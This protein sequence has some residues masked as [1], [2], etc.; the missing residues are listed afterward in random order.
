MGVNL[1]SPVL[2]NIF[3]DQNDF[4]SVFLF[5]VAVGV[6]RKRLSDAYFIPIFFKYFQVQMQIFRIYEFK[7][8]I[9]WRNVF[10]YIHKNLRNETVKRCIH[11]C[12]TFDVVHRNIRR[13]DVDHP[14]FFF[15]CLLADEQ[16]FIIGFCLQ[17]HFITACFTLVQLLLAV[18][19]GFCIL[20]LSP[21]RQVILLQLDELVVFHY[22]DHFTFSEVHSG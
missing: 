20:Q 3:T 22:G 5:R 17:I 2:G 8:H 6:C 11:R 18:V 19:F 1:H 16:R 14:Q 9:R 10:A 15:Q 21:C 7:Q 12:S 4:A 13:V